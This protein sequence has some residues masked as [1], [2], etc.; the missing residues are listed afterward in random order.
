[1]E[2]ASSY[3]LPSGIVFVAESDG[4]PPLNPGMFKSRHS[5][6]LLGSL[7]G[8]REATPHHN[9]SLQPFCVSY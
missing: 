5:S 8:L 7:L 9:L 4:S 6:E 3:E 2:T 1:M